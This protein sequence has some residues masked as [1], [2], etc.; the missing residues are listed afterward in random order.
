MAVYLYL[1][2][3]VAIIATLASLFFGE[4]MG[5]PICTLCWYQRIA[6]Y[7]LVLMLPVAIARSDRNALFY[8]APLV[9]IGLGL[10]LYH[11]L[12]YYGLVTQG[13][14]PCTGDVPCTARQIEWLGFVTIPLMALAAFS[15][16]LICLVADN[17][18]RRRSP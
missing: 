14:T 2:W 3:V 11:N 1:A 12:L 6:L 18:K 17:R 7:P 15:L 4:V 10:A 13:L 16:I 9:V 5:L 8:A